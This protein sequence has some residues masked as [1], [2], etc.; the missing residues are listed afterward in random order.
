MS[1]ADGYVRIVTQNDVSEAQRSTEQ[2]GD[3]IHD[4]LDTTPANNM[5]QAVNAV[6]VSYTHLTLP[7]S[8]L[9]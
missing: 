1:Q 6:P 3:T 4:A 8:D 5:T 9:V 7:T 2:L